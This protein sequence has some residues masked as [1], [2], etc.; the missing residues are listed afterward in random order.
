MNVTGE[1]T[2][3]TLESVL[4]FFNYNSFAVVAERN[5]SSECIFAVLPSRL[6]S[7]ASDNVRSSNKFNEISRRD[8]RKMLSKLISPISAMSFS[9]ARRNLICLVRSGNEQIM[10]ETDTFT[11]AW[12]TC[13]QVERHC[14]ELI[15]RI[16]FEKLL[17]P[18]HINCRISPADTW[19]NW[20]FVIS[21]KQV[22]CATIQEWKT[23]SFRKSSPELS[24][25]EIDFYCIKLTPPP[26]SP[27]LKWEIMAVPTILENP[28][29]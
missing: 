10:I 15:S 14:S 20:F 23:T 22:P 9:L 2:A 25:C 13:K 19:T 11:D 16:E 7:R 28:F 6:N 3:T 1:S 18:L 29:R 24:D 21:R 26:L 12:M 27:P 17:P 5:S 8:T 4:L